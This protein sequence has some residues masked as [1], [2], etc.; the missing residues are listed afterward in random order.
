MT[1][2]FELNCSTQKKTKKIITHVFLNAGKIPDYQKKIQ[3][4]GKKCSV[5]IALGKNNYAV[6]Y[7]EK[8]PFYQHE[9]S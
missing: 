8:I 7:S 6:K 5:V 3:S 4:A 9:N 1:L 2:S